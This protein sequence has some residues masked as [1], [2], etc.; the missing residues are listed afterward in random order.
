M[1]VLTAAQGDAPSAREAL[2]RLCR[3]YWYPLYAY[4]RRRG[5]S[6]TDAEDL[7]QGFFERLLRLNSIASARREKG[8]FRSFLLG[9]MDHFLADEWH[10]AHAQKRGLDQT[11][12]LDTTAAETRYQ[13][14]PAAA[15]NLAPDRLFER[16]WALTLLDT[17]LRQLR[18]EYE[19][20]GRGKLFLE[21]R[22]AIT[23]DKSAVPYG[24]LAGR[25]SMSDQAI[26]VA[27]H[28]LRQRYREVLRA[29]IADTVADEAEIPA[30]LNYLRQVLAN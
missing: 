10:R 20:T 27:V 17:A 24:V 7:T 18:Q 14:E 25:L 8:R 21:L 9:A 2:E 13:S 26:R 28:R 16:Q 4:V 19:S 6:P 3:T 22:F 5:H 29:E 15:A 30:E 23:G 12:S 11:L 1:L